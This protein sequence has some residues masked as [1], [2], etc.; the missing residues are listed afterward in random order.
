MADGT[1]KY[2][3]SDVEYDIIITL[4]NLLQG[5]EATEKYAADAEKAGDSECATIF[6]TLRENNRASAEQFRSALSRHLRPQ[7]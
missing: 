1:Q 5:M 4:S 6:R 3:M 7:K 2:G